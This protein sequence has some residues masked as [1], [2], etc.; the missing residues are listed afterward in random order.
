[1]KYL[2]YAPIIS[3]SSLTGQ[4]VDKIFPL[5]EKI[6]KEYSRQIKTTLVNKT[7]IELIRENKPPL[8]RGKQIKFYYITQIRNKPP[9]FL[10]FVNYPKGV[11][12]SYQRYILNQLRLRFGLENSPIRLY[13]RE[14]KRTE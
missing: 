11:H 7:F 1:M 3:L 4:R 8:Y 5:I 9:T 12:F 14:R 2:S 10:C 13:F 6:S